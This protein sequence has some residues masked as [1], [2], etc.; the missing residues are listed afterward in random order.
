[1]KNEE[2]AG[3]K[4]SNKSSSKA[5]DKV[6]SKTTSKS[7]KGGNAEKVNYSPEDE[8]KL[9]SFLIDEL[10]DIYYAEDAI[11][12]DLKK[13]EKAATSKELK[14]GINKHIAQT[15]EHIQRL[16]QAFKLMDEKAAKKKCEAIEGILKEGSSTVEEQEE[17]SM[18]RDVAIIVA[19]QK[20]EHYEIAAYG[21]LAELAKTL[22]RYDVA[23]LLEK[24]LFEEKGT[25]LNLS[26]LAKNSI[27]KE[28]K[29][30]K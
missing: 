13:M 7:T 21:T 29:A 25:D 20:V 9:R 23:E 15:Q 6:S 27:N 5:T 30:E 28:A 16:E 8:N 24:T 22:G 2:K 11:S 19:S 3:E 10:K 26:D 12:K 17:G 18:V 4:T 1:M 14:D